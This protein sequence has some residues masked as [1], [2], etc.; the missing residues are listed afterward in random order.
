[1]FENCDGTWMDTASYNLP[2]CTLAGHRDLRR[3]DIFGKYRF[4]DVMKDEAFDMYGIHVHVP[5]CGMAH[6]LHRRRIPWAC[7]SSG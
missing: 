6:L 5:I 7:S 3:R 2:G 4:M 1:M